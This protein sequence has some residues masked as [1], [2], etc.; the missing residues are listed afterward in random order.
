MLSGYV[1]GVCCRV[2]CRVIFDRLRRGA[3]KGVIQV[4]K[5]E[6]TRSFRVFLGVFERPGQAEKSA[7]QSE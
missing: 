5:M 3:K 7:K 1:V 4:V 2:C 6:K